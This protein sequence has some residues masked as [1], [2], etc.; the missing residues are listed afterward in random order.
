MLQKK[1]REK[2]KKRFL[3]IVGAAVLSAALLTGC[4]KNN[5]QP[6]SEYPSVEDLSPTITSEEVV[7]EEPVEAD[8]PVLGGW[9]V[10]A[11]YNQV[12]SEDELTLFE[13]GTSDLGSLDLTPVKVLAT[14]LVSGTNTAY[15]VYGGYK[16][17]TDSPSYGIAIIYTN[18]NGDNSMTSL[19]FIDPTDLQISNPAG[20]ALGS[21]EVVTSGKP[22]ML[23]SE[24]AEASF[25]DVAV[26]N[27]EVIQ[28]PVALLYTQ[29]VA[30]T[31]YVAVSTGSDGN[32]YLTKWYRDL[33]GNASIIENGV[34]YWDAYAGNI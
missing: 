33:Q 20:D 34:V 6:M 24:E 15:L 30:G 16:D 18:L 29:V 28:N 14:Q 21:W 5:N 3:M 31:N 11:D 22:G 4:T 26:D 7:S 32:L 13:D 17:S 27:A 25:E 9:E 1:G 10:Y 8:V 2:M 19:V 23:P 12:L